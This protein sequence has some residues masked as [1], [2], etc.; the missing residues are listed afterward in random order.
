M[1]NKKLYIIMELLIH[2]IKEKGL[3]VGYIVKDIFDMD[4]LLIIEEDE[5]INLVT[6]EGIEPQYEGSKKQKKLDDLDL[7]ALAKFYSYSLRGKELEEIKN[8][9]INN[10]F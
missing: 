9:I 4:N 10:L 6:D 2:E 5:K 7:V 1:P 8:R 3:P